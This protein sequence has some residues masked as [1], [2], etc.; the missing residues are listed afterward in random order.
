MDQ[1]SFCT[2]SGDQQHHPEQQKNAPLLSVLLRKVIPVGFE[3]LAFANCLAEKM[4]DTKNGNCLACTKKKGTYFSFPFL[5]LDWFWGSSTRDSV[6]D[7]G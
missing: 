5:F 6:L 7:F 2:R 1:G 4:M 3:G